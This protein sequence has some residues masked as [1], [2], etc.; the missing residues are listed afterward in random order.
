MKGILGFAMMC[1]KL[2]SGQGLKLTM[3]SRASCYG[4]WRETAAGTT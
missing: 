3:W 1:V 4:C 2:P